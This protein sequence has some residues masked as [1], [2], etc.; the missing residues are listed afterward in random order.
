MYNLSHIAF[1]VLCYFVEKADK[2]H[3]PN[4]FFTLYAHNYSAI[5]NKNNDS[6][7]FKVHVMRN[8]LLCSKFLA[9]E[10]GLSSIELSHIKSSLT[11]LIAASEEHFQII[12]EELHEDPRSEKVSKLTDEKLSDIAAAPR[13]DYTTEVIT[14]LESLKT[15]GIDISCH[16]TSPYLGSNE[17]QNRAH[18]QSSLSRVQELEALLKKN[19]YDQETAVEEVCDA[20]MKMSWAETPKRPQAIFSFLGPAATGKTYMANLIAEGLQGYAFK[21]FDMTQFASENEGFRLVGLSKGFTNAE[22]GQLTSFVKE[23]PRSVIVFDEFE[24]THTR[25]QSSLLRLFSDGSIEDGHTGEVIDFTKTIIVITSNLGS[26]LY[27]N[28]AFS[29]QLKNNPNQARDQLLNAISLEKKQQQSAMVQAIAPEMISRLSQ[30]SVVLFNKM[31]FSGLK[32][33]A[34][35]QIDAE[36]RAL[37]EK[38]GTS[39]EFD[40]LDKLCDL[41]VLGFAP[42]FDTREVKSLL[43]SKLFDPVTDYLRKN[44]HIP[45]D[46]IKVS[47]ST[48]AQEF[49]SSLN[50]HELPKQLMRK[51][52]RIYYKSSLKEVNKELQLVFDEVEIQKLSRS[53]DHDGASKVQVDLPNISFDQI[54]GHNHIKSRLFETINILRN[55]ET[56]INQGIKSPKGMLLYGVPGTG[57]TMLAKAFANAAELPFIACSGGDLLNEEFII[58]LF[59]RAREYAPAIIFIDEIDALPKR[60]TAGAGADLLV[61]RL[62]VEIDGFS[63]GDDVFIIAA[64]NRK[65]MIDPAIIRSGRIDLHYEVP[66]LDKEARRWFIEKMVQSNLFSQDIDL[67]QLVMLSAGSSGADLETLRRELILEAIRNKKTIITE[68]EVIE[69]L[70]TMRYGSRLERSKISAHL[71]ETAYHEAAHAVISKILLPERRIEQITVVAR[72]NFLGMVSYDTEQSQDQT[73]DFLFG[74]TCVALAGRA[75]QIRQF[76]S[77]GLDSGASGDLSQAVT[78]ARIAVAEWGMTKSL[79]NINA[80]ELAKQCGHPVFTQ[81]IEIG[82]KEWMEDATKKTDDLINK[83]WSNIST[84]AQTLLDKEI[85]TEDQLDTIMENA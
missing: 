2:K 35:K 40:D 38:L 65:D 49:M 13:L 60:G 9:Q 70:N 12:L 48:A 39:I 46:S 82:V 5:K 81:E 44:G 19:I 61:N 32:K 79:Y 23:N 71:E 69:H 66:Q 3:Y 68:N 24:K 8:L 74:L 30:G 75:A 85:V 22:P 20:V 6:L 62:L 84:V 63:G 28:P 16:V 33:L 67:D 15:R 64:T 14:F 59:Q 34:K 21:S 31:S 27:A 50:I 36:Q 42:N 55:K 76:G 41:L 77:K 57:K 37:K 4:Q 29:E 18:Q 73:K 17:E 72:A 83:Y 1:I 26:S 54:A 7:I 11:Y 45:D 80:N 51:H 78:C 25:V 56:L 43:T 47:I 58:N 52:Q 10:S 53:G